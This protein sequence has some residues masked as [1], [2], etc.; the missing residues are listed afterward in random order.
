[1]VTDPM[2]MSTFLLLADCKPPTDETTSTCVNGKC[3]PADGSI[4]DGGTC[5][6]TAGKAYCV[7]HVL[8]EPVAVMYCRLTITFLVLVR[9]P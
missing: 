9:S 4:V 5:V 8:V 2:H 6:E 3:N 1:M 7:P